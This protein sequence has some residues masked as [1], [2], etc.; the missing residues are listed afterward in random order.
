M[1]KYIAEILRGM[2]IPSYYLKRPQGIE[3]CIV[4][5][6]NEYKGHM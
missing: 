3:E 2:G 6:F 5:S 4:Y 1:S